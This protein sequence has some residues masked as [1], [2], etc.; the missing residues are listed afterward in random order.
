MGSTWGHSSGHLLG[1]SR[2]AFSLSWHPACARRPPNHPCGCNRHFK[3][4][5]LG[6]GWLG[7]VSADS[8]GRC[9]A[10]RGGQRPLHRPA[11]VRF[12]RANHPET[13]PC[14]DQARLPASSCSQSGGSQRGGVSP[15]A[16]FLV[17][18]PSPDPVAIRRGEGAQRKLCRDSRCCPRGKPGCRGTYGG[19]RKAVRDRFALQGGTGDFT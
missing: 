12:L 16:P 1:P 17:C 11:H 5:G 3:P 15:Q 7:D 14:A 4:W 10:G 13:P 18:F 6:P 2:A 19:H 8:R 9:P